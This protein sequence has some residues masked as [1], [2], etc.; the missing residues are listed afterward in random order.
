V[1]RVTASSIN[2]RPVCFRQE[3]QSLLSERKSVSGVYQF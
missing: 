1:G 2:V 3:R